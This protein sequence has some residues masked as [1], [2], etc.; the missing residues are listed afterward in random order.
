MTGNSP[1]YLSKDLN[2]EELCRHGG[3][4]DEQ[5][6]SA[7]PNAPKHLAL[8]SIQEPSVTRDGYRA[9]IQRTYAQTHTDSWQKSGGSIS[10]KFGS[11]PTG[12]IRSPAEE[13]GK[14]HLVYAIRD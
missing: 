1:S 6:S 8:S 9:R 7:Y 10:E 11:T 13:V 5:P 4:S 3:R 12:K 2:R 14:P